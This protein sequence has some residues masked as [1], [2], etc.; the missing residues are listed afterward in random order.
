MRSQ[1]PRGPCRRA[2]ASWV[3]EPAH[4]PRRARDPIGAGSAFPTSERREQSGLAT[5]RRAGGRAY[6]QGLEP[7]GQQ[8]RAAPRLEAVERARGKPEVRS[9]GVTRMR[10]WRV[11]RR[12][13]QRLH[14]PTREKAGTWRDSGVLR[15]ARGGRCFSTETRATLATY[16]GRSTWQGG[17][18]A[19]LYGSA[20]VATLRRVRSPGDRRWGSRP[21]GGKSGLHRARWWVAPTDPT[22]SADRTGKVPQRRH[23]RPGRLRTP[24]GKGETVRQERHRGLG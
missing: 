18:I 8:H 1:P 10:S 17:H 7:S 16:E 13:H 6:P 9:Q 20:S 23:R 2:A 4:R 11:V 24:D 5:L 15:A 21:T 14:D 22:A 12:L 19:P 3:L